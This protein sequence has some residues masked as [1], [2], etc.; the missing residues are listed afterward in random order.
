MLQVYIVCVQRNQSYYIVAIEILQTEMILQLKHMLGLDPKLCSRSFSHAAGLP[1][2][3]DL[4]KSAAGYASTGA[5]FHDPLTQVSFT[6]KI[7]PYFT[8]LSPHILWRY[9]CESLF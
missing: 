5:T 1:A 2:S 7:Q 4:P 9:K 3:W 8:N 6:S